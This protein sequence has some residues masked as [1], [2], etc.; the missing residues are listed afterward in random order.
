[1]TPH[2]VTG[3]RRLAEELGGGSSAV[4]GPL[5]GYHH[6]TYVLSM[7]DGTRIVK[8]REPRAEILWFDRRCF[9]SEEELLRALQGQVGRIPVIFDVEG[10]G[11][12][13]FIAGRT[14]GQHLLWNRRVPDAVF[15]QVV[16][17]FRQMVRI[18]PDMLKVDRRCGAEDRAEE[19]DC[20]GFLDRLVAFSEER[21]FLQNQERF[22]RLFSELGLTGE[23][24]ALLR[25]NVSGLRDR[26]F[27]L[28]HADLHRANLIIDG[29]GELWAIDWELAMFGDPLYDLATHLYLMRYPGD[30]E[31]RMTGE[32]CRIV[33]RV[34]PGSSYGWETDLPLILNFKRAQSA[35]TDTIRVS[36]SLL[37]RDG[38]TFN[39]AGLPWAARKLRRVLERAAE[40]LALKEVPSRGEIMGALVRWH[41]D[42]DRA[43]LA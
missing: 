10:M 26:P 2:L 35:F 36:Q 9:Q 6:D 41:A 19:G 13:G 11:L 7:P 3:A 28:L 40:P 32:W 24:F 34:R 23:S 12:Q 29:N 21:V 1:M 37:V 5:K 30:Q 14:V 20:N 18:T 27:C 33:E 17:L 39:W 22:G 42:A 38:R 4:K 16:D 43:K 15:D 31:R 25:K 8:I